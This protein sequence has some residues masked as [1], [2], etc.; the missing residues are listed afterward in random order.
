M[1]RDKTLRDL[2][3]AYEKMEESSLGRTLGAGALSLASTLGSFGHAADTSSKEPAQQK[4]EISSNHT[5]RNAYKDVLMELAHITQNDQYISGGTFN[6]Y[7]N[8][9][10]TDLKASFESGKITLDDCYNKTIKQFSIEG[11]GPQKLLKLKE[12]LKSFCEFKK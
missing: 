5:I 10:L 12:K 4:T 11:Y 7:C 8:K 6:K 9:Y 3:E 1:L 2:K